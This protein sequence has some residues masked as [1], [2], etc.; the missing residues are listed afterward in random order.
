MKSTKFTR[1]TIESLVRSGQPCTLKDTLEKGLRVKVGIKRCV[2]QY[3]KRIAGSKGAAVTFTIGPFP[4]YSIEE[5]RQE[6]RRLATLCE[7][8]IDPRTK[9]REVTAQEISLE[10]AIDLFLEAKQGLRKRVLYGYKNNFRNY[11]PTAWYCKKLS[12][13]TAEM[14]AAQFRAIHSQAPA[15]C[16]EY[17][18]LMHNLWNTCSVMFYDEEGQPILGENPAIRARQLLNSTF[19]DKQISA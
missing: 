11:V 4:T 14:I 18:K 8:G 19:R 1:S 9:E 3:E 10:T 12:E 7:K 17:L 6:A 13:I 15:I 16:W 5:A 2:F